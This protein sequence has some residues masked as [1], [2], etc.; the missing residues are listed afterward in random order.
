MY[1]YGFEYAGI[2]EIK[3]EKDTG[4]LK[5]KLK[6]ITFKG[7]ILGGIGDVIGGALGVVGDVVGALTG[8]DQTN[9]YKDLQKAQSQAQ[10]AALAQQKRENQLQEQEQN[11]AN[12][13]APQYS[14]DGFY[15]S[16]NTDNVLTG[17]INGLTED[18]YTLGKKGLLGV[19]R[20]GQ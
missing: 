12:S 3:A 4:T 7:G 16:Y 18:D 20:S 14:E 10:Q 19:S 1:P 8:A 17:N 15:D 11:K 9:A 6:Y 2:G 13:Q 5:E